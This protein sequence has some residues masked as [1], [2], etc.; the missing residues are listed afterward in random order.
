MQDAV[1]VSFSTVLVLYDKACKLFA[2]LIIIGGLSRDLDGVEKIEAEN[3]HNGFTVN[4]ITTGC[5]VNI[6]LNGVDCV[7]EILNICYRVELDIKFLH[8]CILLKKLVD[9]V[10]QILPVY[11]YTTLYGN[12][13][14]PKHR[15]NSPLL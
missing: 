14:Y 12:C 9:F 1:P 13:Q 4:R 6:S 8:F 5:K 2:K 15:P 11:K 7:N 3:T 10:S